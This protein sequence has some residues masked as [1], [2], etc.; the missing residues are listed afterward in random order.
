MKYDHPIL[1]RE[2]SAQYALGTL[3]GAA[4][5]RFESLLPRDA[6]LRDE[7]HWW[8][9]RLARLAL[10]LKPVQPRQ[11]VW[12]DLQHRALREPSRLPTKGSSVQGVAWIALAASFVIAVTLFLVPPAPEPVPIAR[13]TPAEPTYWA[14]LRPEKQPSA[15][16]VS[17][18]PQAGRMKV[19]V[20][21]AYPTD[22]KHDC[23]LWVIVGGK[24]VSAGVMPRS[25]ELTLSWP[26]TVP[27]A[28]NLVLAVSYEPAGGSPT[29]SP[30]GPVLATGEMHPVGGA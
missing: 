6:A 23:E 15:W 12:L 5:R 13:T 16:M 25:G 21:Q 30:T 7:L 1:R 20:L 28:H 4:R 3:K 22:A 18:Q 10:R 11:R 8:E 2:L 27:F 14:V 26:K 9:E 29:G 24:P 19:K 17:V